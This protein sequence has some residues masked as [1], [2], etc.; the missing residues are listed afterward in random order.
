MTV[1]V[2]M[3]MA[4]SPAPRPHHHHH[5]HHANANAHGHVD[6]D[7]DSD[8][9]VTHDGKSDN[10]GRKKRNTGGASNDRSQSLL[11]AAIT[12][13][14][15]FGKEMYL[16]L[17]SIHSFLTYDKTWAHGHDHG[18]GGCQWWGVWPDE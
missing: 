11:M 18:R 1:K 6:T 9:D 7:D 10:L 5:H 2:L 15:E 8:D 4:L 14:P 13:A 17:Q 16:S 3:F 12:E